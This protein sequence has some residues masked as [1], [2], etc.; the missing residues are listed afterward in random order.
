MCNFPYGTYGQRQI[1]AIPVSMFEKPSMLI[2]LP[3]S[4]AWMSSSR[5]T[6]YLSIGKIQLTR[7]LPQIQVSDNRTIRQG[8]DV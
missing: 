2:R 8:V 1:S 5:L 7:Q 6:A 3:G 4:D